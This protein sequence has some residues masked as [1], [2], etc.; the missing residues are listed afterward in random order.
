[1]GSANGWKKI[2]HFVCDELTEYSEERVKEAIEERGRLFQENVAN[3]PNELKQVRAE[4]IEEA[5]KVMERYL[6][7]HH[8]KFNGDVTLCESG[9][10][11]PDSRC[12][13][14]L[15]RALKGPEKITGSC[16]HCESE[17]QHHDIN[18]C[19]CRCHLKGLEK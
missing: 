13:I 17:P 2:T 1:M 7:H 3:F 5:A 6:T 19:D 15:V 16:H 10:G 8:H 11:A 18:S 4:A 14:E 9:Y 12:V